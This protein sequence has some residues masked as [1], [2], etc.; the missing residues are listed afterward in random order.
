MTSRYI[1]LAVTLLLAAC[2]RAPAPQSLWLDTNLPEAWH[3]ALEDVVDHWCRS[4]AE[5]CPEITEDYYAAEGLLYVDPDYAVH[6]RVK[7]S[8][9]FNDRSNQHVVIRPDLPAAA[10]WFVLAHEI[11]HYGAEHTDTGVMVERLEDL[12]ALPLC[13]DDAAIRAWCKGQPCQPF[14]ELKGTCDVL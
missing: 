7:G 1:L 9:A 11:G 14:A 8:A 10:A 13:L 5:Y 6:G 3:V 4:G 12:S 2:G